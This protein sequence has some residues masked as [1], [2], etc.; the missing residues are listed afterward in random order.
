[1]S[2][3]EPQDLDGAIDAALVKLIAD[4]RTKISATDLNGLAI[5]V[6]AVGGLTPPFSTLQQGGPSVSVI[7]LAGVCSIVSLV[8]HLAARLHSGG[9]GA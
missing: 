8:L 2:A 4:E 6:F 3:W 5:A 9:L 7:V 1:M